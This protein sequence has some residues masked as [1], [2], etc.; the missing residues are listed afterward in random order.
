MLP[1]A[2][3]NFARWAKSLRFLRSRPEWANSISTHAGIRLNW[4][5]ELYES[6]CTIVKT[7]MSPPFSEIKRFIELPKALLQKEQ[8]I[9]ISIIFLG[10]RAFILLGHLY[11]SSFSTKLSCLNLMCEFIR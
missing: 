11:Q 1:T 4:R 10:L 8:L 9:I 3:P 5:S 2:L 7:K 6:F